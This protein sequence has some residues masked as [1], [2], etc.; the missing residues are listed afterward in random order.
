MIVWLRQRKK[1][2]QQPKNWL[3]RSMLI[4]IRKRVTHHVAMKYIYISIVFF[5]TQLFYIYFSYF[6]V[7]S[8]QLNRILKKHCHSIVQCTAGRIPSM[9]ISAQCSQRNRWRNSTCHRSTTTQ[10]SIR[11]CRCTCQTTLAK[12]RRNR[13]CQAKICTH[14]SENNVAGKKY[15]LLFCVS[16]YSHQTPHM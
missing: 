9:L 1:A 12:D 16:I 14:S 3:C 7:S 8:S 6:F 2:H 13:Y 10:C 15:C 5:C 4:A 11:C